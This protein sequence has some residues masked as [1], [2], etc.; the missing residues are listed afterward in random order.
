M[1]LESL[2]ASLH[3]ESAVLTHLAALKGWAIDVAILSLIV[4]A[5]LITHGLF[6]LVEWLTRARRL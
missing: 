4:I 2:S 5:V 6:R 3:T 1:P